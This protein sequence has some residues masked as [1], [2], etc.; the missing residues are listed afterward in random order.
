MRGLKY[1]KNMTC[2]PTVEHY[3]SPTYN[4]KNSFV[5]FIPVYY[6]TDIFIIDI[7]V[8]DKIKIMHTSCQPVDYQGIYSFLHILY[9]ILLVTFYYP[10]SSTRIFLC[11]KDWKSAGATCLNYLKS[12]ISSLLFEILSSIQFQYKSRAASRFFLP[13]I[14]TRTAFIT[15]GLSRHQCNVCY[16]IE[17]Q[18]QK[19]ET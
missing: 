16:F 14:Y 15:T 2:S 9:F 13:A 17:A 18:I 10:L 19:Y 11:C 6:F 7:Y 5:N 3:F 8:N 12:L 4:T 1:N